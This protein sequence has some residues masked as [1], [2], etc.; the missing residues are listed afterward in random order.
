MTTKSKKVPCAKHASTKYGPARYVH[1]CDAC[2]AANR[3]AEAGTFLSDHFVVI[4]VT[5]PTRS[6]K[7]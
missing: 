4:P 6:R 7:S 1:L 5:L 3:T 2:V